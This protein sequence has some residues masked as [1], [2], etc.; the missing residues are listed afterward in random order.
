LIFAHNPSRFGVLDNNGQLAKEFT[1]KFA[2]G[3]TF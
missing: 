1:F 2:V 3:S